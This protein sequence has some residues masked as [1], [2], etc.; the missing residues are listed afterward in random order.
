MAVGGPGR[1]PRAGRRQPGARVEP[2]PPR[3]GTAHAGAAR[4][5]GAGPRRTAGAPPRGHRVPGHP[6]DPARRPGEARGLGR[7]VPGRRR[8]AAP[9]DGPGPDRRVDSAAP[10]PRAHAGRPGPPHDPPLAGGGAGAVRM[11]ATGPLGPDRRGFRGRRRGVARDRVGARS[12]PDARGESVPGRRPCADAAGRR[13][14]PRRGVAAPQP[15]LPG[16]AATLPR[17][18]GPA[19][20]GGPDGPRLPTG[21][22]DDGRPEPAP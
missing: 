4:A 7:R 18:R 12:V 15:R 9:R 20:P 19:R 16:A 11:A 5:D 2:P 13:G 3:C 22:L 17:R 10:R 21:R 6:R 14:V 8:P 1:G